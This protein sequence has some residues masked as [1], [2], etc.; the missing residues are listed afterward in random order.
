M[1]W[2]TER[3]IVLIKFLLENSNKSIQEISNELNFPNQS[4]FTRYFKQHTGMTPTAYR[5]KE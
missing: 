5:N 4:F 1:E 3:T 2:I